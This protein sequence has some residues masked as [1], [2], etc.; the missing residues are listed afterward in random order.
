MSYGAF[1]IHT[2]LTLQNCATLCSQHCGCCFSLGYSAVCSYTTWHLIFEAK[3]TGLPMRSQQEGIFFSPSGKDNLL[4]IIDYLFLKLSRTEKKCATPK[5]FQ[6]TISISS[7]SK[8][9]SLSSSINTNL[10]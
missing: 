1:Y 3:K 7:F 10:L 4:T 9:W 2:H 5:L 6:I 8:S